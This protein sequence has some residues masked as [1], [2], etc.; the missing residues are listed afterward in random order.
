MLV[1][2]W[3]VYAGGPAVYTLVGSMLGPW[4]V[5]AGA[6]VGLCWCPA[7]HPAEDFLGQ[8][9]W[10]LLF[11]TVCVILLIQYLS[12]KRASQGNKRSS[13][14]TVHDPAVIVRRQEALE[15][16]RRRL[17]EELDAKAA[18]FKEKQKKVNGHQKMSR[19]EQPLCRMPDPPWCGAWSWGV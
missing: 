6:L 18:E 17:Q 12:K 7:V 16:S 2:P 10:Y 1:V 3:W 19:R 5:Y 9:G 11:L 8:Y 4:W 13:S 14:E 15:A